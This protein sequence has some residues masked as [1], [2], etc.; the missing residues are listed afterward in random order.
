MY[1]EPER[2]VMMN[3][4]WM[5]RVVWWSIDGVLFAFLLH[6]FTTTVTKWCKSKSS[7]NEHFLAILGLKSSTIC[8]HIYYM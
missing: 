8:G 1:L 3:S 4:I 7:L 5:S 6:R 2:L